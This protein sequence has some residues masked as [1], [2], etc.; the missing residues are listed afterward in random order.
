M[1]STRSYVV[2]IVVYVPKVCINIYYNGVIITLK[3][4]GRIHNAQDIRSGEMASR[5]FET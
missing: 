5:I 3:I 4:K 1:H 2:L